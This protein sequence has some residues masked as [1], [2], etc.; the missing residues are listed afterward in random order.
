MAQSA[1]G[2]ATRARPRAARPPGAGEA[3]GSVRQSARR[4]STGSEELKRK[5]LPPVAAS[6]RAGPDSVPYASP[7]I[8]AVPGLRPGPAQE[9]AYARRRTVRR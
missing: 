4:W 8:A 9:C 3:R 5:N 7:L 1:P 6:H 2:R